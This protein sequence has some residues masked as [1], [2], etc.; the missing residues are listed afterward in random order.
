[1]TE[2]HNEMLQREKVKYVF[3]RLMFIATQ[4]K[5]HHPRLIDFLYGR[6]M[7]DLVAF[8]LENL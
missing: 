4:G 5:K 7:T 8:K 2:K 1:M 3:Q 6:T